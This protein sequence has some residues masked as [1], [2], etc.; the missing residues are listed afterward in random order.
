MLNKFNPF[1]KPTPAELSEE[2][3]RDAELQQVT[4]EAML[5][6]YQHMVELGRARINRLKGAQPL[7]YPSIY[8]KDEGGA[9]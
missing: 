6:Y 1:K 7:S 4:N 5:E 3:L 2:L 8:G 9:K